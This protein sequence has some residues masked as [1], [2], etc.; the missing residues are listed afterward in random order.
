MRSLRL[1]PPTDPIARQIGLE[2]DAGALIEA[3]TPTGPAA[4][5]GLRPGD[6]IVEIDGR[7]FAIVDDVIAALRR[8]AS[9][10][11]IRLEYIRDG[12]RRR[13]GRHPRRTMRRTARRRAG[14]L[15]GHRPSSDGGVDNR[16]G[17]RAHWRHGA[18]HDGPHGSSST[19]GCPRSPASRVPAPRPT[20]GNAAS[21]TPP[22][23]RRAVG[24]LGWAV[25][26][27]IAAVAAGCGA[28]PQGEEPRTVTVEVGRSTEVGPGGSAEPAAEGGDRPQVP[29]GESCDGARDRTTEDNLRE[30][31]VAIR[32][33]TNAVRRNQGLPELGF[34]EQLARAAATRSNDMVEQDYFS[35]QGPDGGDV[36]SAVRRTGYIPQDRSWL[37]GE[38]IGAAPGR[39]ATPATM[40]RNWLDSPTHRANILS[41]AFAEMGVGA[42]VGVP[43]QDGAGGA[44]YTQVFGVTGKAARKAQTD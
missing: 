43:E 2:S 4:R 35:H 7:D 12:R 36:Q 10:D 20:A 42:V 41:Q 31:E 17:A 13:T 32:C 3:V 18:G 22:R 27:A 14:T 33:L 29:G 40:M 16:R 44:T 28:T 21:R 11:E 37:L 19:Y 23:A 6:V 8:R 25:L 24:R 26:A 38:N 1:R 15:V 34:D 30:A 39:Q 5:A 9:G